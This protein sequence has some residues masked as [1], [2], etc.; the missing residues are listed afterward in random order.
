MPL[1]LVALFHS[2]PCMAAEAKHH[3]APAEA[4]QP[5]PGD[6][7]T[8]SFSSSSVSGKTIHLLI[9]HSISLGSMRPLTRVYVTDPKVVYA[10]TIDPKALVVTA[11]EPGV[12]SVMIWDDSDT[13]H[14]FLFSSDVDVDGLREALSAALP[15]QDVHV[16]SEQGHVLLSG[17][18][19]DKAKF[20]SAEKL[21]AL[22]AKDVSNALIINSAAVKQVRLKVRIVEIDRSRL[23]QLG[24][25]FF[26]SGGNT[27]AQSSTMQFPST[28][29][30][31][32]NGLNANGGGTIYTAGKNTVSISNPLNFLLYSSQLNVGAM[33][34]DMETKQVLQILAEPNITAVSGHDASF[35]AGGE[36]P[37][38]V[39]QGQ[40]G[41][42]TSITVQFR[43][44]GVKLD[45]TPVVNNDGTIQLTVA[46]EVSALDYT[47]AVQISGYTIPA[48]STRRAETEVVL[49]NGQT[50][51]ISGLLDNRMTDQLGKTPGIASVPILGAF[52]KSKSLNHSRTELLVLV[53]PELVNPI[54]NP[55]SIQ[56]PAMA[57]RGLDSR[58]FDQ[59][60]PPKLQ[61]QPTDQS[62]PSTPKKDNK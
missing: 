7:T 37:F 62:S 12:S 38:P 50:F 58:A 42:S 22:Y 10:S 40:T 56:E 31:A 59:S 16:S 13:S 46:P 30:A 47:N 6:Q 18:V 20:D 61:Q 43:P 5:Q 17:S 41:G 36:F 60:L 45:F 29:S 3:N 54:E 55:G 52:F 35:L 33:L 49:Q 25:N 39:V 15:S 1:L 53:T 28:L 26:S 27:L 21:A 44:Y 9:G 19:S 24:F 48:L 8:S 34:Q 11:K 14:S 32:A 4:A 2:A 51:A 57:V 23:E